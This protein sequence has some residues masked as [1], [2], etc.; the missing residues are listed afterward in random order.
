[1]DTPQWTDLANVKIKAKPEGS[2]WQLAWAFV[3]GPALLKME[4]TGQWEYSKFAKPCSANGDLD[5]PLD[6]KGS[7]HEK[8][9]LGALI[10]RVGGSIADSDGIFIVGSVCV[11]KLGKDDAGPLFLAIND[12]WNGFEDNSSELEVKI[13]YAKDPAVSSAGGK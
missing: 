1:M 12:K 3:Q 4:A 6:N 2:I 9:A 13:S 8:A 10:G 7:V 11:H 5:S